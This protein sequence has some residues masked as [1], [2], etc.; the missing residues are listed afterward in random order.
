VQQLEKLPLPNGLGV[1][2]DRCDTCSIPT[3][4]FVVTK[5]TISQPL[6]LPES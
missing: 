6:L 4:A 5:P 2:L 3:V 1:V